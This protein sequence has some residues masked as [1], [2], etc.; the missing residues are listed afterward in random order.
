MVKK[1]DNS[2]E[3][4]VNGNYQTLRL[5]LDDVLSKLRDPACDVD[6]AVTLYEQ[7][8]SLAAKLESHLEKAE[9][10]VQKVRVQFDQMVEKVEQ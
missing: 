9:N 8:V 6:Q 5:Q 4:E 1:A 7:A 3:I 10:Q 2:T